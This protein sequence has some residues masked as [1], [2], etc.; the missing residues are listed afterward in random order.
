MARTCP[1][2]CANCDYWKRH[3][4]DYGDHPEDE[5]GSCKENG[6]TVYGDE[7]ACENFKPFKRPR[8]RAVDYRM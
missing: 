2:I 5:C 4:V 3:N 1:R 7:E 8:V 6:E